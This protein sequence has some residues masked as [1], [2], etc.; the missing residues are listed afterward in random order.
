MLFENY[1]VA[2]RRITFVT[3]FSLLALAIPLTSCKKT[4][5]PAAKASTAEYASPEDAGAALLT[6][7]KSD[8]QSQMISIFGP[9]AKQIISSGD[10]VQDK[11]VIASFATAY[12]AMHRW[13]TMTDGSET[14]IV[15]ADNFPFPIPLKK[16]AAGKWFFDGAAGKEEV[17]ARRVGRNELTTIEVAKAVGSAQTEY[18]SK[19]HDGEPVKEYATKFISDPGKQNG[20]YWE[21]VGQAESPLGKLAAFASSEGYSTHPDETKPFHGY[22]YR[23]LTS[24]S[25]KAPHGAKQ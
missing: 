19:L 22:L 17:L 5:T 14:L 7:T 12:G 10:A 4:D 2:R 25:D 21:P 15:G 1:Q 23:M 8:D 18:F 24:Q 9:D 6:A 11:A 16:N 13:R 3:Q 20:L